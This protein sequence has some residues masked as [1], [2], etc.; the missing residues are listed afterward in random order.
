MT[1][2]QSYL[3][4]TA[5]LPKECDYP[6]PDG[7]EIRL[8]P[9]VGGGGMCHCT[10]P[11]NKV[12]GAVHHRT[13]DEIW[14]FVSGRGEVWRKRGAQE[15]VDIV[16]AGTCLTIPC[17][18]NF[19]FRNTGNDPLCFVIATIPRWPGP[20]EAVATQGRWNDPPKQKE[21]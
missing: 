14:Y 20:Q 13:V 12:S 3:W 5:Q 11:A 9:E 6:A 7:T 15:A 1:E 2:R 18:T 8:L 21:E 10:L 19:Q 4:V 17:G 16:E